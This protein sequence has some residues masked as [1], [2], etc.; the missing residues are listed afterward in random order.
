MN[1]IPELNYQKKLNELKNLI[2]QWS[3]RLL[4]PLGKITVIKT[5]MLPKLTH[6]FISLP[7]PDPNIIDEIE[8]LF[9]SFL[10]K[11]KPDKISR[12]QIIQNFKN[13][14]LNM[15]HLKSFMKSMKITWM[16]RLLISD[17]SW[18]LLFENITKAKKDQFFIFG[19]DFSKKIVKQIN[20]SFWKDTLMCYCEFKETIKNYETNEDIMHNE[21]W[22]N[23]DIKIDNNSIF[24]DSWFKKDIR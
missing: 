14:G 5:L 7:N 18:T 23:N 8:K 11:Q 6:L 24:Y 3:R 15:I 19:L 4:S 13:G 20:N 9:F 16:K 21:L 12:K 22:F 2:G 17:S 1:K 10:W